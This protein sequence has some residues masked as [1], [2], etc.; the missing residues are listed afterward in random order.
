VLMS[1]EKK[2]EQQRLDKDNADKANVDKIQNVV[3][4]TTKLL[5]QQVAATNLVSVPPNQQASKL[6]CSI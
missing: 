6:F 1:V 5:A 4:Q 2:K 3:Q